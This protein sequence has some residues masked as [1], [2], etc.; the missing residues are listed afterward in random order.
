MSLRKLGIKKTFYVFGAILF[1]PVALYAY[2]FGLGI[3]STHDDW[4]KMGSALG[5]IYAPI[6]SALTLYLIYRQLRLQAVIHVD[7]MDWQKLQTSRQHGLYLCDK[8]KELVKNLGDREGFRFAMAQ[9]D[10]HKK[11]S[12][13][14]YLEIV[15]RDETSMLLHQLIT[16][17]RKL[18]HCET[19]KE[20]RYHLQGIAL[21]L[22][23]AEDLNGFE[24]RMCRWHDMA[25]EGFS[26]ELCVFTDQ[27]DLD[28][29]AKFNK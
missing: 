11:I 20:I 4:A 27:S 10:I 5:G 15:G 7:Q 21:A 16:L 1:T 29:I 22:V 18:R 8:L 14:Q 23:G 25:Y 3:W 2:T 24:V 17:L 28:M 12:K 26:K 13:N 6:L 19:G 9:T